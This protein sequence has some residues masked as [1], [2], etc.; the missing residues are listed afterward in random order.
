MRPASI[1]LLAAVAAVAAGCGGSSVKGEPGPAP[2]RSQLLSAAQVEVVAYPHDNVRICA[3]DAS[4]DLAYPP[5]VPRCGDG[6][7]AVG[8]DTSALHSQVSGKPER[9]G[10]L[11]LVG[12]YRS[13]TFRVTA[14]GPWRVAPNPFSPFE[15]P[16]PCSTPAGGWK[17]VVAPEAQRRTI[18]EYQRAHKGDL[19]SVSFFR[20]DTVLVV[21]S[22]HPARTR[23][24]LGPSWPR[25]LCVVRARYSRPFVN[26]LRGRV[27]SLMRPM[28]RAAGYGWVTGAGG[29]GVNAGGQTTIS[30]D[31]LIETPQLRAFLQRLPRGV[32]AVDPIFRPVPRA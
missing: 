5:Q 20:D 26:R 31:V 25:Q 22:S 24:L 28:S 27:L 30:L 17:L 11:H 13:S 8:V 18:E 15:G 3:S 7:R 1:A 29:Y 19:V 23:A 2:P 6:L 32:V 12:V 4:G 21:A 9:W 10:L 14:Q 16:I